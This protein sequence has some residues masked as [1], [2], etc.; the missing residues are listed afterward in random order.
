M[1][2]CGIKGWFILSLCTLFGFSLSAQKVEISLSPKV[3]KIGEQSTISY[4]LSMPAKIKEVMMPEINDTLTEAVEVV[5]ISSIDS[6]FDQSD[7][8]VRILTQSLQ[9]TSWDSGFHAIPPFEFNVDGE[10]IRSKPLLLEVKTISIAPDQDIKD[11][12]SIR[13]VPFSLWDWILVH[14]LYFGLGLLLIVLVAG[15]LILYR[16]YGR[17]KEDQPTVVP[18]EAAD[19]LAIKKLR[20]LE[21]KK[22]WENGKIKSY[23]SALSYTIREYLE[24]RFEFNAL[25]LTTDEIVLLSRVK[26]K[27]EK[28]LDTLS[29]IL[30]SAD[31][32]KYAKQEPL[33]E[34]NRSVLKNAFQFVE[35]TAIKEKKEGAEAAEHQ[36]PKVKEISSKPNPKNFKPNA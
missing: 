3:I 9:I 29:D 10:V 35:Q 4:S 33:P 5:S 24:N 19:V 13:E 28:L 36:P 16:K 31:L 2:M 21:Q 11:I 26:I 15:G 14:R 32:A 7:I 6:S 34:V 27:N 30:Q 20:E 17:K 12:K 23:Y 25:E 8:G 1:N 22:L 18:K